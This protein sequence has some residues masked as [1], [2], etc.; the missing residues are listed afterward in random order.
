MPEIIDL[1]NNARQVVAQCSTPVPYTI[2]IKSAPCR[3]NFPGGWGGIVSLRFTTL[4]NSLMANRR[5]SAFLLRVEPP[6]RVFESN[7]A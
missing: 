2:K 6:Y 5:Y 3:F 7:H 4:Q 1:Y